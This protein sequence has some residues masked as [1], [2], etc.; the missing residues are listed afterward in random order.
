M[1][2][3]VLV[4]VVVA[5][6]KGAGEEEGL[7]GARRWVRHGN[8]WQ[9]QVTIKHVC[10]AATAQPARWCE[11]QT[12]Q[13]SPIVP[14]LS[15]GWR[16]GGRCGGG[17]SRVLSYPCRGSKRMTNRRDDHESAESIPSQAS[18]QT[19]PCWPINLCLCPINTRERGPSAQAFL[20]SMI[21]RRD[22]LAFADVGRPLLRMDGQVR[23]RLLVSRTHYQVC[24]FGRL[25]SIY[26][27][28]AE[29]WGEWLGVSIVTFAELDASRIIQISPRVVCDMHANQ[30]TRPLDLWN[31]IN[32]AGPRYFSS[33]RHQ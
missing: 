9:K 26:W 17:P 2:V 8:G 19:P 27:P 3:V 20:P 21:P 23:L 22:H 12:P 6:R 10:G 25:S 33:S 32:P 7:E 11:A 24:S 28:Q 16:V 5:M 1:A 13:A 31:D 14:G 29:L 4:V 15:I 30:E 18:C